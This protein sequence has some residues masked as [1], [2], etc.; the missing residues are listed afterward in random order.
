MNLSIT[1]HNIEVTP[2]L[3]SYVESKMERVL[4]RSDRV[5]DTNVVL[6]MEKV[7]HLAEAVMRVPGKDI[8]VVGDEEDMY[9]AIDV[10]IDKLDRQLL[11]HKDR[12]TAHEHES[13]RRVTEE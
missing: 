8:C 6:R 11:K 2:A 5:I 10:M 7:R 1:G 12:L 3:R 13:V 9:A 4:R